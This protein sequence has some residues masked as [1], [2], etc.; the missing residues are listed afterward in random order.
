[1]SDGVRWDERYAKGDTRWE[2][3]HPSSELQ[4]VVA[5]VPIDPCRVLELG[6]DTG[7]STVWLA[8]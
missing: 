1:M 5:K 7:A 6:C 2:T 4:R 8:Q 3:R